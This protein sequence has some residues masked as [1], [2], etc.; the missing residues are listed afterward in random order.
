MTLQEWI[1]QK[2]D[3][4]TKEKRYRRAEM[5]NAVECSLAKDSYA[6]DLFS[7]ADVP[8]DVTVKEP[9]RDELPDG[10][11]ER[12]ATGVLVRFEVVPPRARKTKRESYRLLIT[13]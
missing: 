11:G 4:L 8:L 2:I 6:L 1:N 3:E 10:L 13:S 7:A 5:V 12:F 9:V